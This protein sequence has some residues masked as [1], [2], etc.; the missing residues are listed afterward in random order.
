MRLL[1]HTARLLVGGLFLAGACAAR[2]ASPAEQCLAGSETLSFGASLPH[3]TGLL[4]AGGPLTIVAMGSSSTVSLWMRDPAKTYPG[5]M[6][7]ELKRL[8]PALRVD[9]INSGRSGDTIPGNVARFE[10]DVFA[11]KPDLVIWQVGTNDISWGQ[12]SD[13]LKQKIVDG[14]R[15]LRASGAEVVL[16]DQ[17]YAPV[18]LASQYAKMQAAIAEAAQ[19]DRVALFPRFDLMRR[20]VASGLSIGA[21]ISWDGLHLSADGYDCVGRALARALAAPSKAK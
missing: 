7:A 19:Q 2:G 18:I 1:L 8:Q 21:L 6:Q 16:M 20:A 10:R 3:T 12:T 15:M 5:V 11:H 13:S 4:K 17:Q 9:V 14:V